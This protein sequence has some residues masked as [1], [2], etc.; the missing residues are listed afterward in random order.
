MA[1]ERNDIQE[2]E[3]FIDAYSAGD[4]VV[5]GGGMAMTLGQALE[6]ERLLCPADVAVRQDP[7]RRIAYLASIL[8]AAGSLRP[9][10]EEFLPG[11]TN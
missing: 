7:A 10:H 6:A 4:P 11:K 3:A 8:A 1:A 9:E 5:V 2:S